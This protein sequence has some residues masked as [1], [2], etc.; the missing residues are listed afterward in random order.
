MSA[1]ASPSVLLAVG[2]PKPENAEVVGVWILS[3]GPG[4]TVPSIATR[5]TVERWQHSFRLL[6]TSARYDVTVGS[7][8]A[9]VGGE[10]IV[11]EGDGVMDPDALELACEQPLAP[12]EVMFFDS[13]AHGKAPLIRIGASRVNDVLEHVEQAPNSLDEL[14]LDGEDAICF[15]V[16]GGYFRRHVREDGVS[17]VEWGLLSRLQ[18]RPGGLVAR[19]VNRPISLRISRVLLHTWVTPNQVSVFA[20][21]VGLVGVIA[22]LL[23][24]NWAIAG[25]V[26]LQINSIL[27]GIDGELARIRFRQSSFGAYLD[28]VLDEILNTALLAATGYYLFARGAGDHYLWMGAV[29]GVANFAY[30]AVHWHCK[31]RHGLGFYWWWEAY[32]PRKQVQRSTSWY[33]YFKKLFI[34]ES[35]YFLYIPATVL[36]LL[37]V[38]VWASFV[39]GAVVSVLLSL[40]IFVVRARW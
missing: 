16:P 15:E 5:T 12:S 6:P 39:S 19:Y 18:W 17:E 30:A 37:P 1:Q 13:G 23:P 34:K 9:S 10:L 26:L 32:K 35:I 22:F 36:G 40:H 28:S 3:P 11:V 33:A 8:P 29:G 2:E 14:G 24:G 31:S 38:V 25:A 20:A 21:V 7:R 4:D 27:D